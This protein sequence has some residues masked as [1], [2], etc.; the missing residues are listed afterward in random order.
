M[1]SLIV[2]AAASKC[3]C[4]AEPGL[5]ARLRRLRPVLSPG[6]HAPASYLPDTVR[7]C[8]SAQQP[9]PVRNGS[10]RQMSSSQA[11]PGSNQ[12]DPPPSQRAR[13]AAPMPAQTTQRARSA[14]PM[15]V[16][17]TPKKMPTPAANYSTNDSRVHHYTELVSEEWT[18]HYEQQ[19]YAPSAVPTL[20]PKGADAHTSLPACRPASSAGP[21]K[22]LYAGV[23]Q[24]QPSSQ[25]TGRS[26]GAMTP[27]SDILPQQLQPVRKETRLCD[28][29]ALGYPSTAVSGR[30]SPGPR[31][32]NT[33]SNVSIASKPNQ[34]AQVEGQCIVWV[35][36]VSNC[37]VRRVCA[38]VHVMRVL[39]CRRHQRQPRR[40]ARVRQEKA[41]V[42]RRRR[43]QPAQRRRSSNRALLLLRNRA[44]L[45]RSGTGPRR[46]G[47]RLR[48]IPRVGTR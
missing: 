24:Q 16:P 13:S 26:A 9:T 2:V 45:L 36:R 11:P 15:P 43:L 20:V 25:A 47:P 29:P 23:A 44:L 17:G 35:L 32:I 30:N 31:L 39:M 41:R 5:P 40:S 34:R 28:D 6:T 1:R 3:A 18:G 33:L 14:A 46:R 4:A 22:S 38:C 27:H 37:G 19:P 12:S 21:T 10:A 7:A 48:S 8:V 42:R